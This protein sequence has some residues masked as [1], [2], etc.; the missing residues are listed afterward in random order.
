MNLGGPAQQF[1]PD[2]VIQ[3]P[4]LGHLIERVQRLAFDPR[5]LFQ[6]DVITLHQRAEGALADVFVVMTT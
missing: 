2:A 1:A 6:I 3:V 5:R 4:I